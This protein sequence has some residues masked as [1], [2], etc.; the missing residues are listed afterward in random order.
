MTRR[1]Q[2]DSLVLSPKLGVGR[3]GLGARDL[4]MKKVEQGQEVNGSRGQKEARHLP[5]LCLLSAEGIFTVPLKMQPLLPQVL[6]ISTPLERRPSQQL[7][8]VF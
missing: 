4:R 8:L 3:G 1:D 7:S 5:P 2:E 6:G